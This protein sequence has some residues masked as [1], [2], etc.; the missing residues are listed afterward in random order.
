MTLSEQNDETPRLASSGEP[1]ERGCPD[2][3]ADLAK[4]ALRRSACRG[5]APY[6]AVGVLDRGR[7]LRV[8]ALEDAIGF[9][10]ARAAAACRECDAAPGRRCDDHAGDLAMIAWYRAA[11]ERSNLN[12]RP[13]VP[14]ARLAPVGRRPIRLR[15]S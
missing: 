4:V 11:I 1:D 6:R 13:A 9:R 2:A 7:Y 8:Q 5:G 10:A 14:T 3:P 15:R 12:S